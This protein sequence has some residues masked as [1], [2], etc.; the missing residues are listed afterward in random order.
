MLLYSQMT[1]M[2]D[3]LEDYLN[4]RK[5]S[6]LRLDGSTPLAERRNMVHDYQTRPDLF[7][8]L[9]STRAGGLGIN[10]TSADTVIFYDSDWNPTVDAQAMDRTH[11]VGQTKPVTVYRLITKDTIEQRI[12]ERAR[13][14]AKIQAIVIAGQESNEDNKAPAAKE[15]FAPIGMTPV[16]RE[17]S[18]DDDEV[19]DNEEEEEE[20]QV[21]EEEEEQD[22][23]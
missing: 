20:P 23:E 5:L 2:M 18:F 9:M 4:F 7:V 8:F 14:K 22:D 3:V 13:V 21:Q 11:R 10:L 19:P 16:E 1:R 15:M 6:Y 12:L 17:E